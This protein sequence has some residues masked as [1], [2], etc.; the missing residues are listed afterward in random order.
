MGYAN[1]MQSVLDIDYDDMAMRSLDIG[2]ERTQSL[3][4]MRDL[5]GRME[6]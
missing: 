4:S 1:P 6:L 2:C 5:D 3:P